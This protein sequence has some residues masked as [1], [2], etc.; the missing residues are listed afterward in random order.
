MDVPGGKVKT[1]SQERKE[2]R[3]LISTAWQNALTTLLSACYLKIRVDVLL[4]SSLLKLALWG[5]P[6][7]PST[8]CTEP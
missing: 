1:L 3:S 2:S 5:Q 8:H 7:V 6:L 4:F